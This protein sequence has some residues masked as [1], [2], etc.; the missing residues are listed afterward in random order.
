M[1]KLFVVS[2]LVLLIQCTALIIPSGTVN[3]CNP[4]DNNCAPSLLFSVL[5]TNSAIFDISVSL[6]DSIRDAN[7]RL[8]GTTSPIS[9]SF[10]PSDLLVTFPLREVQL[11]SAVRTAYEQVSTVYSGSC[12]ARAICCT[13][14]DGN[15]IVRQ[16]AQNSSLPFVFAPSSPF[17][18]ASV[19]IIVEQNGK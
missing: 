9:I 16:F 10:R 2:L 7:G 6:S 19:E 5:L 14:T 1:T 17:V 13:G 8:W 4:D 12:P 11:Q 18:D 15:M 3:L